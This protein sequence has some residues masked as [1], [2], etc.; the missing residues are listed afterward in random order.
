[1]IATRM[2]C[3]VDHFILTEAIIVTIF[4]PGPSV[5]MHILAEVGYG[6]HLVKL[7]VTTSLF[8]TVLW[9]APGGPRTNETPRYT[10][11]RDLRRLEGFC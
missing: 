8:N 6:E 4:S 3:E 1:M 10:G 2:V 7:C 11:T 9:G 5:L